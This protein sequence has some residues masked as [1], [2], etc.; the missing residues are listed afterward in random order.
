MEIVRKLLVP[1]IAAGM[2]VLNSCEETSDDTAITVSP[3]SATL[4][5]GKGQVVFTA[6]AVSTNHS[7]FLPLT[8]SVSDPDKGSISASGGFSA[9]YKGSGKVGNNAV[10]VRDQSGA[11]GV[12]AV[13]QPKAE[14]PTG[15]S[16]N[17]SSSN[18]S[19]NAP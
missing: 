17:N 15:T 12:A 14:A 6:S 11:D 19:T 3:S 18:V 16:T 4:T 1:A 10:T 5:D 9:V 2:L 8:W 13:V 7:L